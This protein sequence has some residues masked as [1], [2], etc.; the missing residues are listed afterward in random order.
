MSNGKV[1]ISHLLA[2][3]IKKKM[4]WFYCTC[5]KTLVAFQRIKN[6]QIFS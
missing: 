6:E 2:G 1:K 3:L 4:V 5:L